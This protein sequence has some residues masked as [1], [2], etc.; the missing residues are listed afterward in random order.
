MGFRITSYLFARRPAAPHPFRSPLLLIAPLAVCLSYASVLALPHSGSGCR[1]H[2]FR[3]RR[4]YGIPGDA[5]L[6]TQRTGAEK[7]IFQL[8][9]PRHFE[10]PWDESCRPLVQAEPSRP[11]RRAVLAPFGE[12]GGGLHCLALATTV[13]CAAARRFRNLVSSWIVL[14]LAFLL[15]VG[16]IHSRG[17][18]TGN[19]DVPADTKD[20][21]DGHFRGI[22]LFPDRPREEQ[23]RQIVSLPFGEANIVPKSR[24]PV[25]IRFD[26]EYWIFQPPDSMPPSNATLMH[27]VPGQ[28]GFHSTN[29]RPIWMEAHQ[30]LSTP[31]D[32]T[33]CR[34]I[35]VEVRNSDSHPGSVPLE[36]DCQ[37]QQ[38]FRAILSLGR[39]EIAEKS[40]AGRDGKIVTLSFQ[41]PAVPRIASFDRLTFRFLP[42]PVRW[43]FSPAIA[44]ESITIIPR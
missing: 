10:I 19:V 5:E 23:Q 30:S 38:K 13:R 43:Q 21:G 33:T 35:Q 2:H 31:V 9:R 34:S 15:T 37:R 36:L 41:V 39:A 20:G 25:K 6:P 3:G 18:G 16:S 17:G 44:I 28:I 7:A 1:E 32:L 8:L 40:S 42:N 4:R 27:G 12:P 22:F 29:S 26:G 24:V 14:T 11:S